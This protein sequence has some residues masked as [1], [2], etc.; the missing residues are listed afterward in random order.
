MNRVEKAVE[1]YKEDFACSQSVFA[2]FCEE[3]DLDKNTA[4]KIA[5]G[6]GSGIGRMALTCGA[7]TGSCMVIGLKNGRISADDLES[8]QKTRELITDFAEK[9]IERN[10][11]IVCKELLDCDISTDEGNQYAE[12]N[13]IKDELCPKFVEDAVEILEEILY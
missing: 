11:T 13:G 6:F 10:K 2:V 9:F 8:K 12:E 4:L 5:E 3:L 7:V 1:M